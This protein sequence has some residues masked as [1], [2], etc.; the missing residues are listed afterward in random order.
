[1]N[2]TALYEIIRFEVS[3]RLRSF[4]TYFYL[5]VFFGLGFLIINLLTGVP[6]GFFIK[7]SGIEYTNSP[8]AIMTAITAFGGLGLLFAAGIFS[9]A[10]CKDFETKFANILF[11]FPFQK[12]EYVTGRLISATIVVLFILLGL[13]CG[14]LVGEFMPWLEREK[15]M[16]FNGLGYLN[17]YLYAIIPNVMIFGG[18]CFGVGLLT[19]QTMLVYLV[20]VALFVSGNILPGILKTNPR[21]ASLFDPTGFSAFTIAT[22]FWTPAQE[23]TLLVPLS[24][25]ILLNRLVWLGL[26]VSFLAFC[27]SKFSFSQLP[28]AVS[29]KQKSLRLTPQIPPNSSEI[30]TQP[31]VYQSFDFMHQL[32]QLFSQTWVESTLR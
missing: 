20:G 14:Y 23:A 2:L 26:S 12:W 3:N 22:E 27:F 8:V 31:H 9:Q 7:L 10:A 19:R 13:G 4:A 30:P 24:S 25:I 28:S 11:T 5:G 29:K 21:L 1:M 15:L 17:A 16:P 32:S 18:F 6:G